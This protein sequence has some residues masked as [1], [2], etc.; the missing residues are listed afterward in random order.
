MSKLF[1]VFLFS[2]LFISCGYKPTS[3]YTKKVLG[4]KIYAD[5]EVSLKDPE[6]SVLI[7]DAVN[8]AIINK[9]RAELVSKERATSKLF[10][11]LNSVSFSPLEYDR[12]GYVVAYKTSV[13]LLT[14]YIDQS[15]KEKSVR[16][17]GDYDFSIESNS[18]ISDTKR[19]DAI[20][21]ASQK[22]LDSL[23]SQI[24]VKGVNYDRR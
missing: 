18:I 19:F 17:F 10:V 5:I 15:S 4:N 3:I 1:G 12:N 11:K 14:K 23:I 20:K 13:V 21:R 24:S 22:A 7:R 8:E 6:N 16:S 9:F 2:L